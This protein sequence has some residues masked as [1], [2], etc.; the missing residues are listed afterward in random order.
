MEFIDDIKSKARKYLKTIVLPETNDIRVIEAASKVLNE[1]FAKIILLGDKDKI[2]SQS[3]GFDISKAEIINP[4]NSQLCEKYVD[5]LVELRAHKG[6]TKEKALDLLLNDPLYFGAALVKDNQ[7]DG[8]VAGSISPT[9]NVL[10]AAIQIVGTKKNAKVV[11]TFML[12]VL[13]DTHLGFQHENGGI[14]GFADCALIQDPSEEELAQIAISSAETFTQLTGGIPQV[15]LLSH[16]TYGSAKHAKID[17]V[18]KA[19]NIAK[20][21]NPNLL[22][23]GELQLDAAIVPSVGKAKAPDSKIAGNANVLVFPDIDSGNIGYKLVQRLAKADAYGPMTQ[24]LAQPINDLS[25]GC[26][27]DD[28]VG[29]I[30]I[31]ALQATE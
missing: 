28:I 7:A 6:M 30:A 23:D 21:L 22:I 10:R 17:K 8:M 27:A 26:S 11:S 20:E 18:C 13:K 1:G 29:T 5:M 14:F 12:M 31:S 19:L 2:H 4:Q 9:A 3:R 15:A 16:S 25:R 24:G